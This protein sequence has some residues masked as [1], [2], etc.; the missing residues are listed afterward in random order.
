MSKTFARLPG[1]ALLCA[2]ALPALGEEALYLPEQVVTDSVLALPEGLDLGAVSDTGSRLGLSLRETPASVTVV[3]RDAIERRGARNTREMLDGVPGVNASSPPGMG[4]AVTWRGFGGAQIGQLFNGI[5]LHYDAIAARPVDGWI[6]DRVEAIGGASGFLN[7]AGAVGGALN[8]VTKLPKRGESFREARLRYGSQDSRELALGFN[9]GLNEHLVARLDFSHSRADSA[10]DRE[11]REAFTSAFSLLADINDRLSHTLALEY[12]EER[13]DTPYWGTPTLNGSG[14]TLKVDRDDRLRNF[15]VDDSFYQQRVRWL[16]S[17]TE[18]QLDER[19]QWRNT[20]YHYNASRSFQNL[21]NYAYNADN[22][23]V[24][25]SGALLQRHEQEV[26]GNRFELRREDSLFGLDSR[27]LVGLDY[28]HNAQTRYPRSLPGVV[29]EVTPGG[30]EPG[31]FWDIPGMQRGY[32]R[33]RSNQV[34]DWGLFFEHHLQLT[35]RLA[36]LSGLR[37]ERIGLEVTNHRTVTA[38]NPASFSHDYRAT[39]GR[40]GLVY[41]LSPASN[42]Y[43]QYSTAADPPAGMLSTATPGQVQ[44]FDL[45]RGS[46]WEVGVKTELADGRGAASLAL[47]QIERRNLATTDPLNPG[48][49][50]AVGQQYSRGLELAG[51]MRITPRLLAEGSFAYTDAWYGDFS[52]TVS[53]A[54]VSHKGN[55]PSNTPARVAN[56]WLTYDLTPDWQVGVDARHVGSVYADAANRLEAPGY[57]LYGA[58]AR[59]RLDADTRLEARVRNLTDEVYAQRAMPTMLY[60]GAPRSVELSLETRF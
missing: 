10:V 20:L 24:I 44:D 56:L 16:R 6:Y 30:F 3:D 40:L 33:D 49:S 58:F 39:T 37:H 12:Q 55:T 27:W 13:V 28:S 15:N 29:D 45:T 14:G 42:L 11:R 51:S 38:D 54:S 26:N 17:I 34:D 4:N 19:T 9:Q 23:A 43:V 52:E 35:E 53:G 59:V 31:G 25:R 48:Q 32:Q 5:G 57:T 60:L 1:A 36:V 2:L 22:S 7:G 47:Y 46:Q 41:A 21:E 8:Y 18:Y 50:L